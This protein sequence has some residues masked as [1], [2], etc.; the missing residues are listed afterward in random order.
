MADKKDDKASK[1]AKADKAPKPEK[2]DKAK[3]AQKG[4][5]CQPQKADKGQKG[6]A[7]AKPRLERAFVIE[8]ACELFSV[9]LFEVQRTMQR[10]C[11]CRQNPL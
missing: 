8:F 3:Q 11:M 4:D 9:Q 10:A 2:G 5:K 7:G 1:G 6:D